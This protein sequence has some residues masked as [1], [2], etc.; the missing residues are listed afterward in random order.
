[1]GKIT[2]QKNGRHDARR[3]HAKTMFGNALS[4]YEIETSD[5]KQSAGRVQG[6]I[7]MRKDMQ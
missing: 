7:K 4:H 1:M 2:K 5:E 6:G 3:E